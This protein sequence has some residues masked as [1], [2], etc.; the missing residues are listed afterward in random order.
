MRYLLD[1]I[2]LPDVV[3]RLDGRRQPTVQAEDLVLD[4]G[5]ERQIVKQVS[6]QLPNV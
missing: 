3:Q 4:D 2:Q 5:R 6:E 1:A